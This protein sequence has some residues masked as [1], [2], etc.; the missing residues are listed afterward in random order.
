MMSESRTLD[1]WRRR[2]LGLAA[3]LVFLP[4]TGCSYLAD[5]VMWLDPVPV[6]APDE[7]AQRMLP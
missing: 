3:L 1:R 7:A 4:V 2:C 6:E 5:E